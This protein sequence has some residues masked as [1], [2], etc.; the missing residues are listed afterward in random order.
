MEMNKNFL[1]PG[2]VLL[3]ILLQGCMGPLDRDEYIHWIRDY[4]NGLHV[5]KQ[6]G[7][8]VVDVQYQPAQY[9]Q[10]Q[11][12][13][14]GSYHDTGANKDTLDE[15]QYYILTV[16]LADESVDFIDYRVRDVEEK[17][18]K[19]YYFSYRFQYDITLEEGG[20]EFP[21]VLYHFERP[22][23]LRGSRTI[24][25]GF[26]Q[27]TNNSKEATLKISADHFG[28]LPIRIK[29]SKADIPDVKL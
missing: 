21:C 7:E 4:D 1:I 17:Q 13:S 5:S 9:T 15:I 12:M 11:K 24:L 20:K 27:H 3:C 16:G 25:L 10:L 28:A 18:R 14:T 2:F 29:V 22:V 26:E 6:I 19:L 23:D 8:Y